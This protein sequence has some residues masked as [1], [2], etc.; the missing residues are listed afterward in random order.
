MPDLG[1][2]AQESRLPRSP[3][4]VNIQETLMAAALPA[5]LI[6]VPFIIAIVDW[7]STPKH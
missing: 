1:G 4:P 6:G 7:L 2:A 3:N 5:W